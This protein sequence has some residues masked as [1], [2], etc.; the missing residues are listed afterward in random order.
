MNSADVR[1]LKDLLSTPKKIAVVPHKNPDGDAIGAALALYHFLNLKGHNTRVISPNDYPEFL[2]W[3]PG[4]DSVL[5]FEKQESM[6]S[7]LL[8]RSDLIFTVDFNDL[9]RVGDMY[10]T[11]KGLQSPFVMIDHHQS[12]ADYATVMYSDPAM[13]STC[14]MVFH[15]LD[16]LG[17]KGSISSQIADCL[18]AGILTDTGSFKYAS[19]SSETHRVAAFLME[20]GARSSEIH[21]LIFDTNT[22]SR[23]HLLGCA[24]NNMVILEE[25]NTAYITLSQDELDQYQFRKGDTEGFVNYGLTLA[26]IRMAV[27]FI[28]N[29][30]EGI[31]KISFRSVGDFSVNEFARSY[32]N[33]GGHTNA[34]GGRSEQT[35]EETVAYFRSLVKKHKNQLTT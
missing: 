30:D 17:E 19:T 34:A 24:L 32:F 15:T 28:E 25:Y 1:A 27:I 6:A 22:P 31:I 12:P 20:K 18:Y 11:L 10:E 16:A 13:S 14:E 33:G 35:L 2:K 5:N 8:K 26:G 29:R 23:L 21:R 7:D 9:T 3:M 4:T